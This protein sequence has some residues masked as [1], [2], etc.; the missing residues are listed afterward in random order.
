M[1]NPDRRH[2]ILDVAQELAQTRGYAAFS[3]RDIA[4]R[5]GIRAPSIHHHFPSKEA[6][7]VELATRYEHDFHHHLHEISARSGPAVTQ[8]RA[9]ARLFAMTVRQGRMCLCGMLGAEL[10]VLPEAVQAEVRRF[11]EANVR[12]LAAVVEEGRDRGELGLGP[13][14]RAV[15]T[16]YLSLLEGSM[17]TARVLGDDS[18]VEAAAEAF[19]QGL[20]RP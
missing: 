2:Q 7:G 15:G 9:Y 8:L 1:S 10:S 12:W 17:T 5:V 16:A 4:E 19:L 20:G 13:P 3:F 6:L 14:A 18:L 11:F